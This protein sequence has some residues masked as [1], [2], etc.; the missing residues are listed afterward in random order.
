MPPPIETSGFAQQE[1]EAP[2]YVREVELPLQ[3]QVD[4]LTIVAVGDNL[5]HH[6]I[7]H[8]HY[9]DG[10]YCFIS[11]FD[12]IRDYILPAD[13]AFVNQ[14]TPLGPRELGFSGWPLFSS[15][16][17]MGTALAAAGF[18]VINHTNNH[19]LDRG[20]AGLMS[21]IA[22]WDTHEGIYYLGI[23]RSAEE[24]RSRQVII[25]H[26][27]ITVGF[28]SYS[29]GTNHI[30]LPRGRPYMVSLIDKEIMSAE[31][32][33]LRPY[34]DILVVSMHWGDEYRFT[35]NRE[36]MELALFLAE[37]Q[38]DLVIGHHPHVLQPVVI[39]ERP[40]G[41]PMPVFFSLGNFLSS[42][43]R[44]I[45]EAL[46]GGIM[47]VRLRKTEGEVE[48][49]TIG[50]I[51][52]ITHYDASRRNFAVYPLH[53]YT[54]EKAAVHWSRTNDPQMTVDFFMRRAKEIVDPD[55]L[56]FRNVFAVPEYNYISGR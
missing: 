17:E 29:Y 44:P 22:Y 20:E 52:I 53:A 1:F 23:H 32:N 7:L 14:E 4:Y 3:P 16:V 2:N 15:P 56:I 54:Y 40:D 13:I 49:D 36:Q 26:N 37:H 38:V 45:K 24:R 48:F 28:L 8:A 50:L 35:Y 42:H 5:I 33:A 21:S 10:V 46:L 34:C 31:I 39:M 19:V 43:A 51:P 55:K 30:P 41:R 9:N 6:P 11:I 27:N 12:P 25:S 18:N 47:Y